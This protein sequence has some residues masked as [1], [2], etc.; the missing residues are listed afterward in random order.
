M[1]LSNFLCASLGH[2]Y[3]PGLR[4]HKKVI[5]L[6]N[7]FANFGNFFWQNVANFSIFVAKCGDFC[8]KIWQNLGF[9]MAIF[10]DASFKRI[11]L[12]IRQ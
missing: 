9:Q 11:P 7:L 10:H 8:G 4:E 1:H 6:F 5:R 3:I 2:C 12:Y